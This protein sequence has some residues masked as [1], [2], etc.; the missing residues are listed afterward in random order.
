VLY[1]DAAGLLS[2]TTSLL[3]ATLNSTARA[4]GCAGACATSISGQRNSGCS[5]VCSTGLGT[6]FLGSTYWS[7]FWGP[8]VDVTDRAV[9]VHIGR[10][11]KALSTGRERDPIVTVRGADYSFDETF[12]KPQQ[13]GGSPDINS[14]PSI[15]NSI[16]VD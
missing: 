9:D 13:V 11:R 15:E 6:S 8:S 3:E 2:R 12:G 7:A 5:N 10:L 16:P 1:C 4:E 14:L